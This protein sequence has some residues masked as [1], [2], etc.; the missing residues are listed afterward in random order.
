MDSSEV[1][2]EGFLVKKG[3]VR[4]N[5]RTRWFVL[6]KKQLSYFR[7]RQDRGGTQDKT[8]PSAYP[9]STALVSVPER[10]RK[11]RLPW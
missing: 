9:D 7:K 4:H 10:L 5:W 2:K 11:D 3:H 6:T 1:L 8:D